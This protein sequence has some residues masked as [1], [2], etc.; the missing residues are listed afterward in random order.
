MIKT[1]VLAAFA[2]ALTCGIAFAQA[3]SNNSVNATGAWQNAYQ[4][5][6]QAPL[7]QD[8]YSVAIHNAP[9]VAKQKAARI[10]AAKAKAEARAAKARAAEEARPGA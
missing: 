5:P 10:A 3:E 4:S 7:A 8:A 6:Y 2:T 1:L 9:T